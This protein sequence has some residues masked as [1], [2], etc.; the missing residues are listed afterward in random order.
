MHSLP[1]RS[2]FRVKLWITLKRN[3][4]SKIKI[5]FRLKIQW[6]YSTLISNSKILS[7]I[8]G[9]LGRSTLVETQ[10][11]SLLRVHTCFHLYWAVRVK[12]G[13][14]M[15]FWKSREIY[16]NELRRLIVWLGRKLKVKRWSELRRWLIVR[17]VLRRLK[18][19]MRCRLLRRLKELYLWNSL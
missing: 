10:T 15:I 4:S 11:I 18:R 13:T 2:H 9:S 1:I 3:I 17:W 6:N 14:L 5:Y 12:G 8:L 7:V 16:L 19:R